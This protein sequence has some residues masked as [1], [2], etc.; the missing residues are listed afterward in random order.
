MLTPSTLSGRFEFPTQVAFGPGMSRAAAEEIACFGK[1]AL[2]V[3][4]RGIVAAGLVDAVCKP[5][6]AAGVA[7]TVFAD[8]HPNP[9]E[10]D[11]REGLAVLNECKA[12]F[13]L[14]IGGG[15]PI[16]AA[17]VIRL[18]QHHPFP[19]AQYDATR[20]GD[21]LVT[22]PL[23]P[24]VAVPTTSGTGSE[25]SRSAVVT[26]A[27]SGRKMVVFSPR[28]LPT[29]SVCDPALT[30]GL[31]ARLTAATGADALTHAVE[32]YLA[33]GFHP[34]ADALAL[35]SVSYVFRY[36]RRAVVNPQ[37]MEARAY[38]MLA[39]MLGAMAFQKGLGACHSMAHALTA[40]HDTHHGL[41]NA[42]CLAAVV[43][44]NG[45]VVPERLRELDRAA[46]NGLGLLSNHDAAEHLL[47][48]LQGLLSDAGLPNR[49]RGAGVDE[50]D[51]EKLVAYALQDG[52]HQLNPRPVDATAFRRLFRQ[53]A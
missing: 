45:E 6:A 14:A 10:T 16:D 41:A 50:P 27:A 37:D 28:L 39:S 52:C 11:V 32:A 4:D 30:V 17:K 43:G 44:Y 48:E 5:L 47:V 40:V 35:Q 49:L 22:R 9:L 33:Q 15:S 38:M 46:G 42:L 34:A 23:I 26:P 20:G 7:C 29:L 24:L 51:L 3:T 31:S 21:S 53:V 36:L 13:L 25:V 2:V 19:L 1:R 12:D 8:V 18:M